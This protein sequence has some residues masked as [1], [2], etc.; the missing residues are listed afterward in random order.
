MSRGPAGRPAAVPPAVLRDGPADA[1]VGVVLAHGAGAP[2]D[3]PFLARVARE[4]A[5]AGFA[6]LRFEFPYMAARRRG[7]R[8]PPDRRPVLEHAFQAAVAAAGRPAGALVLAGKSMGGRIATY[9]ADA[10]GARAVVALGYPFH[11]PGRPR[12][13]GVALRPAAA[14]GRV[15]HLATLRT[16]TLVVQGTRDAYGSPEEVAGYVLSPAI[17]LHWIADGDHGFA[18]P[19]PARHAGRDGV[20]EAMRATLE[21]LRAP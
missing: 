11:P 16:P 9:I 15:E 1:A 13:D 7:E 6:V 8:R 3:S 4:L 10:E 5:A 19:A 20:A 17:R 2:M 21:F 12:R 14:A 18:L